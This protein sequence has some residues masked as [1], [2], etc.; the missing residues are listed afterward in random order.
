MRVACPPCRGRRLDKLNVLAR[1]LLYGRAVMDLG[2]SG[3]FCLASR[4][5]DHHFRKG[6]QMV[7]VMFTIANFAL[8]HF[9][10][11]G[12]VLP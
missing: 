5:K 10:E 11:W 8:V 7:A 9:S 12:S 4:V 1:D 3:I 6:F 2:I